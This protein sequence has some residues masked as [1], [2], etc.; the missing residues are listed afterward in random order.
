[1]LQN[2]IFL[3]DIGVQFRIVALE[4]GEK[5]NFLNWKEFENVVDCL[6]LE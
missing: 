6:E 5:D 4:K 3:T 1:M 2:Q